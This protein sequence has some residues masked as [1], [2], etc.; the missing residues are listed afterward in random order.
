ME[1]KESQNIADKAFRQINKAIQAGK[2]VDEET[3]RTVVEKISQME[4]APERMQEALRLVGRRFDESGVDEVEMAE[5]EI[6]KN[7]Q[8]VDTMFA[9]EPDT[10]LEAMKMSD[11]PVAV[12]SQ[13]VNSPQYKQALQDKKDREQV[14]FFNNMVA[15]NP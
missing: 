2:Q 11:L 7:Q 14:E 1:V 6:T 5:E 13:V 4:G 9:M 15:G 12:R 3:R 8:I 10:M